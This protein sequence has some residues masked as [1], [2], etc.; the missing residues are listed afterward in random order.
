MY[1]NRASAIHVQICINVF[2]NLDNLAYCV[3]IAVTNHSTAHCAWSGPAAKAHNIPIPRASA[4]STDTHTIIFR[5]ELHQESA[6]LE[7]PSS[8]NKPVLMLAASL[9]RPY[10]CRIQIS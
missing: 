4:A 2:V 7:T 5:L 8:R 10:R 3:T 1:T 6:E 9:S